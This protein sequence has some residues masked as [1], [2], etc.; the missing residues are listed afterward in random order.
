VTILLEKFTD[1]P[2]QTVIPPTGRTKWD[3]FSGSFKWF[4]LGAL[5]LIAIVFLYC[6]SGT[7]EQMS[8][9]IS[10]YGPYAVPFIMGL[11]FGY[12]LYFYFMR[13][14]V[15]VEV[16]NIEANTQAIYEVSRIRFK[17]L[18]VKKGAV[19]PSSTKDGHELYRCTHFDHNIDE[20]TFGDCHDPKFDYASVMTKSQYWD[21]LITHD[22]EKSMRVEFLEKMSYQ[23]TL[24]HAHDISGGYADALGIWNPNKKDAPKV[25]P[26]IP[27][28]VRSESDKESVL[29]EQ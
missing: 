15:V 3:F 6:Y 9:V 21:A 28:P 2:K 5:V 14:Y 27:D 24:V 10:E 8:Y 17:R 1:H 25:D 23:E 16:E 20:I 11:G 22:K 12:F 29:I 4:A 13:D 18:I 7:S 26:D 19:R